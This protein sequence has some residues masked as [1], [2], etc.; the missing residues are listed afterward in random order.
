M[1]PNSKP[2]QPAPPN[3]S[4]WIA[5]HW[6]SLAAATSLLAAAGYTVISPTQRI[7]ALGSRVET[8]VAAQAVRDSVQSVRIDRLEVRTDNEIRE[9]R[10]TLDLLMLSQCF[11]IRDA[12][13]R[14]QM[15]CRRRMDGSP[16]Q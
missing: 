2:T 15:E 13:L 7:D 6:K 16:G 3:D 11:V 10:R 12:R 14:A 4:E 8:V 1:T 9:V 5:R